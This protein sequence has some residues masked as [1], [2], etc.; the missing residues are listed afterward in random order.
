MGFAYLPENIKVPSTLTLRCDSMMCPID[1]N[2]QEH[3]GDSYSNATSILFLMSLP[4]ATMLN[5]I[6]FSGAV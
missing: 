6:K 2:I 3:Y 5:G 4:I 1:D